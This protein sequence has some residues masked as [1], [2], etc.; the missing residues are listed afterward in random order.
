MINSIITTPITIPQ[1]LVCLG[2]ALVLGILS[3]LIFSFRNRHSSSWKLSVALLPAIVTLII[4]MVNGNIGAGLAVAGAF[5]LVRFRSSQG[6][7]REITALFLSVAMGLACGMGYLIVAVIFFLVMDS[8]VLVLTLIRFGEN[9]SALRQ[10]KIVIPESLDYDELFD[11]L[12]RK[13]TERAELIRV[14]TTN[15][16]TLYELRYEL[17]PKP[18]ISSKAFIDEIRCRNGNLNVSY[19]R[20][21]ETETF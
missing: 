6:N 2:T 1:F 7:A 18:G 8:T 9:E 4:M 14:K 20:E 11:D 10:L 13:Y 3:S 5:A 19:G 16:G 15:M 12:F 21:R 17:V